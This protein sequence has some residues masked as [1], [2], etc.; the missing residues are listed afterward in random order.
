VQGYTYAALRGAA[1]LAGVLGKD[2]RG[3]ELSLSADALRERFDRAFWCED[4]HTYALAL[5]GA[6]RPCR[7]K[8]SN[9]GQTLFSGIALPE[10][11]HPLAEQLLGADMFSGWGIRTISGVEHRYNP[12]AYHNGS[13][14]PHDNALIAWGL[15]RYGKREHALKVMAALFDASLF[16]DLHRLP[17][18]FCGFGRRPGEGPTLYPVACSPQA[19]V[20]G[21]PFMLLRA[22]LGLTTDGGRQR[23]S[24]D[25]PA[26]PPFLE[27]VKIENLRVGSARVD[28]DLHRHP[29]DVGVSVAR[30]HGAVEVEVVTVK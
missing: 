20:A 18:L 12:M 19:W 7:V 13:I 5:D 26:L 15:A 28:L 1:R 3:R 21:A 17:E 30:R 10:R 8:S 2:G 22:A 27:Q 11:A 14:W 24:L 4:L 16:V 23:V 29:S 6:K 9:A 25:R